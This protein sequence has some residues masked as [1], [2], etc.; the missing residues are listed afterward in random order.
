[1]HQEELVGDGGGGSACAGGR[2]AC[3]GRATVPRVIGSSES[4]LQEAMEATSDEEAFEEVDQT[5]R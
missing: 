4:S 1:L 3:H 2:S 5:G